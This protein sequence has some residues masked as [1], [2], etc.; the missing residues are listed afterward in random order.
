VEPTAVG[1]VLIDMPLFL[2]ADRYVNVPL[3]QTYLAAYQGVPGRWKPVIE[4]R[5]RG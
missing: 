1:S 5:M 3:E 2:S 4:G